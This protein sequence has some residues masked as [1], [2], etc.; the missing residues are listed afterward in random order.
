MALRDGGCISEVPLYVSGAASEPTVQGY[1]AQKKTPTP[2]GT[3]K[4][5]LGIGLVQGPREKVYSYERGTPVPRDWLV[6]ERL[7]VRIHTPSLQAPRPSL[8]RHGTGVSTGIPR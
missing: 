5:P 4:D 1:L 6:S 8:K 2:L 3:P 7:A